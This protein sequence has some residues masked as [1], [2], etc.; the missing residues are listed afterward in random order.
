MNEHV[1]EE[2]KKAK[3]FGREAQFI[4][5]NIIEFCLVFIIQFMP[6]SMIIFFP[7]YVFIS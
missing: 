1:R 5:Y 2:F 4:E 7:A 3:M 6:D